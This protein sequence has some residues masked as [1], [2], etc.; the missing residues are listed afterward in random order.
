MAIPVVNNLDLNGFQIL[1]VRAQ[2]LASDPGSPTAGQFWFNT[3]SNRLKYYDGTTVHTLAQTTEGVLTGVLGTPPITA[4]DNEDGTFTI[5]ITAA[6]GSAAGSMS[7][8]HWTKLEGIESGATADQSASEILDALITVD[9]ASSG[10]DADLLDGQHGSHYLD[11]ANHS[12]TQAQSTITDLESDLASKID[13]TE[14]G[15]NNGVAELDAG[16]KVPTSQLPDAILGGLQYQGTWDADTNDPAITESVGTQGHYYVVDTAGATEIDGIDDW[17]IG[18]WIVFNGTVWEKVDNSDKVSSVA[19]RAGAVTLDGDDID[20]DNGTSGLA[21]ENVQDALDEV[22]GDI[23]AA[24]VGR[25]S[26]NVGNNSATEI[27]ITHS[28]GT[29]DVVVMVREVASPYAAVLCDIEMLSTTQV[30]L[31]FGAAP[32]T[33]EYRVTVLA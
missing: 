11:R 19:G 4:T 16:G 20:Y 18:D 6:S 15:A 23:A 31:R 22:V 7:S 14:K 24:A 3:V 25:Y 12:G 2:Q 9:G 13:D 30:R 29:R 32:G 17:E 33:D 1:N 26:A 28:L 8:T 27:D 5:A 21:A 10:L